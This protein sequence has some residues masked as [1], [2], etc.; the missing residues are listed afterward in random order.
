MSAFNVGKKVSAAVRILQRNRD[1]SARATHLVVKKYPLIT[2]EK[3]LLGQAT[4]GKFPSV[5]F[6]ERKKM[7]TKTS[8]KRIAL[9]AAA[10]LTLGGF[11]AVSAHAAVTAATVTVAR[12]NAGN[13]GAS[14]LP[15]PVGTAIT[16]NITLTT[17]GA[18]A[19]L[20]ATNVTYTV[21]DPNGTDITAACAFT[22]TSA[23]LGANFTVSNTATPNIYVY[24]ATG[25][26]AGALAAVVTGTVSCPTTMGGVYTITPTAS[27]GVG[28]LVTAHVTKTAVTFAVSGLNVSQGTAL[29][30]AGKA[31]TANQ[32][33]VN[34]LYPTAAGT[35][36]VTSS[37]VGA[38]GGA[39]SGGGVTSN[40]N[41]SGVAT[42]FSQG[43]S[44]VVTAA[45]STATN[46][47]TLTNPATAGIQTITLSSVN[48]GT[49]VSTSVASVTVTWGASATLTPSGSI[50]RQTGGASTQANNTITPDASYSTT[51]DATPVTVAKTLGTP[52]ST[53]AVILV[54][55]DNTP[56]V[57]GNQVSATIAG[58]GL[59]AADTTQTAGIG[60]TQARAVSVTLSTSQNVA[61]VHVS[62][63]G[64]A[65]T[66]TVTISVTDA[67]TG[68]TTVVG[69]KTVTFTGSIST[70][71]VASTNFTIGS[72]GKTTG[73]S[74]QLGATRVALSE[75]GDALNTLTAVANVS[76][77]NTTPAF[78]LLEADSSGNGVTTAVP[79]VSSSD[80]TVVT[81]GTC[82]FHAY[83]LAEVTLTGQGTAAGSYD[84]NFQTASNAVSGKSA[85]LTFKTPS[86]TAGVNLTATATVT[87]GGS[88]ATEVISTDSSSYTPGSQMLVT[89][90]G[91]DSAGNP[92]ADGTASPAVSANRALG[93]SNAAL[94]AGFYVGGTNSNASSVAKSSLFA[95]SISGDFT[96]QATSG[97][98]AGTLITAT[99]NVNGGV[100]DSASSLALDA[101]NAATDAANNAYDEAQNAT[102]AASD[103][104]AAV[105]ALSAQVSA[106]IATVKSLAAMV[107]KIKAKVKA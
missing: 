63:D 67:I 10:A 30:A 4:G 93:V 37:G 88:V 36:K 57:Q 42:D 9:V 68:T 17:D 8:F 75:V 3:A 59:L 58:S 60:A 81:G 22:A 78:V 62:G 98:T 100:G 29:G 21:T 99:S 13:T 82:A 69:T 50:V 101:A 71:K 55:S 23:N 44:T 76:A 53:I 38:I 32:A 19:N 16:A 7:S 40:T 2:Y 90:T 96:L 102:Q 73:A 74:A 54:N 11:S 25:A 64:S 24:A 106:L 46:V 33:Q 41:V 85:I 20:D 65:G 87:V 77:V 66:G 49:G 105:T 80:P 27:A 56:A 94:A 107:A 12:T 83:T 95:P 35:Y 6:L 48:A 51:I 47:F 5:T 1:A 97:N 14:T 28:G 79:T 72:A 89:V 45:S 31:V 91:K 92:V 39:L 34:V 84:C 26:N 104:L 15:I 86:T 70:L 103:A 43:V 52:A 18:V 61:F